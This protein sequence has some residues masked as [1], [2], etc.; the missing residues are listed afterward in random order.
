MEGYSDLTLT[1]MAQKAKFWGVNEIV[2]EA[3]FGDGMFTKVM[4]P[5]FSKIHPCSIVEVKNTK[6]RTSYH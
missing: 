2:V 4:T 1:Q 3:N 6:R 5:I